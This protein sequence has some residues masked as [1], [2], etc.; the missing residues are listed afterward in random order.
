[1]AKITKSDLIRAAVDAENYF[2]D[3]SGRT[4][5][6]H[7]AWIR[8]DERARLLAEK[9]TW[10]ERLASTCRGILLNQK[11]NSCGGQ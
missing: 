9:P 5:K 11:T 10:W 8:A 6:G 3:R 7:I 2:R 1:M 4:L